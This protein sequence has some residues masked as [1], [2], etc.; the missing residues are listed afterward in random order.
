MCQKCRL[1]PGAF[2]MAAGHFEMMR[3]FEMHPRYHSYF[4]KLKILLTFATYSM[5]LKTF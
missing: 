5:L 2:Q 1:P 4:V 3:Q